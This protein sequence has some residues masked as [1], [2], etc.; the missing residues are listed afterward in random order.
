METARIVWDALHVLPISTVVHKVLKHCMIVS[1]VPRGNVHLQVHLG[2]LDFLVALI[3]ILSIAAVNVV[4]L[5]KRCQVGVAVHVGLESMEFH[6]DVKI[7]LLANIKVQPEDLIAFHVQMA[8][9]HHLVLVNALIVLQ[10]RTAKHLK[11]VLVLRV[12]QANM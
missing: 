7:V 8:N 5:A 6:L 4:H 11:S 3:V 1:R 2:V 12:L 10:V 9:I